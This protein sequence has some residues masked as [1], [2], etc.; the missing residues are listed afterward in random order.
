[1]V[2]DVKEISEK[3]D[4]PKR[5]VIVMHLQELFDYRPLDH[6]VYSLT[7]IKD[8]KNPDRIFRSIKKITKEEADMIENGQLNE[9][10]SLIGFTFFNMQREHQMGFLNYLGLQDYSQSYIVYNTEETLEKLNEYVVD[11]IINPSLQLLESVE[12]FKKI[13]GIKDHSQLSFSDGDIKHNASNQEKVLNE[14]LAELRKHFG[15]NIE[16]VYRNNTYEYSQA[17]QKTPLILKVH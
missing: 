2:E 4:I 7:Q 9:G 12:L 10:R 17:L 8:Y 3:T 15:K 5:K 6:F 13:F 1:M 16:R 11:H 14:Y